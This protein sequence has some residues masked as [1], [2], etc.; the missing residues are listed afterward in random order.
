MRGFLFVLFVGLSGSWAV[1]QDASGWAIV[2]A[3]KGL[4]V[5]VELTLEVPERPKPIQSERS[6]LHGVPGGVDGKVHALVLEPQF[7]LHSE[8]YEVP[9]AGTDTIALQPMRAGLR[10][11]LPRVQFVEASFRLDYHSLVTLEVLLEFM[12]VH[13][14]TE[15]IIH[16]AVEGT[17]SVQC[18]RLGR[19]RAR[20]VWEFLVTEGIPPTRL[21]LEGR[22]SAAGGA[23]IALEVRSI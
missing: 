12:Q 2:D 15:L 23:R 7:L 22:C 1:A 9:F 17:D 8:E 3:A 5:A 16:G 6:A 14:T 19:Q 10:M 4:P 20:S 11:E 13:P 18:E 21:S